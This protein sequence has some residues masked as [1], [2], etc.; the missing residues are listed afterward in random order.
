MR[1][2][3]WLLLWTLSL[4]WGGSFLFNELALAGLPA[5][6]VVW[7]R[8]GLA[9]LILWGVVRATGAALPP[10]EMW[11]AL[12]V[13]GLLNNAVPFTLFVLAQGQITG[14]LASVLN[15]MTPV[16][17]VLVAHWA[18][19]DEKLAP[20]RGLG[21]VLGF[22]GVLAMLADGG[23]AG[24]RWALVACLGAAFSYA[25]A[26]VW[27]RRFRAA[28]L[29]PLATAFGQVTASSAL[30]LP[31]WLL[32]DR[33]WALGW[34]GW[35]PVMAVVGLASLS[36]ALAYLIFFRI[37]AEAGA[38]AVSLV[39]FLIPISAAGLGWL[40]LGERLEAR[41]LAGLGLI[42]AGLAVIDGRLFRRR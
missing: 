20:A 16:F 7:G 4:L 1:G 25:V 2:S 15:A 32:A 37:L 39:T 36:S 19:A 3:D 38:T 21:V 14:A 40:V 29:S 13:M 22:A 9:A 12:L 33:P 35:E 28:G 34:P 8:V 6:T 11:P 42:L 5:L 24:T 26:S 30:M 31:V 23:M 17:T 10:R 18:T 41:Q 27:G